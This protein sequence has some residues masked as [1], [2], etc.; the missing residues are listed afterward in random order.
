[1]SLTGGGWDFGGSY[2]YLPPSTLADAHTWLNP[3]P[4]VLGWVYPP[5]PSPL[6]VGATQ[7]Q[8]L[9]YAIAKA[10]L[11]PIQYY[12]RSYAVWRA[13]VAERSAWKHA[14]LQRVTRWRGG[15]RWQSGHL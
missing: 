9:S 14:Q 10:S 11:E 15:T 4:Y 7:E 6:G 3:S 8:Q 1:V 2:P 12:R 5:Q 13:P